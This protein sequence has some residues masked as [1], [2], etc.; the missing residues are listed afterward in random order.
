MPVI[1]SW[2]LRGLLEI[3]GSMVGRVLLSLS[4][5]YVEY[6]GV[7][8][9]IDA[10]K[11]SAVSAITSFGASGLA[12]WAGFFRIDVHISIIISAIGVKVALNG[13]GGNKVRKL[14]RK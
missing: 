10:T 3:A 2:L 12:A 14:V 6:S 8:A 4:L 11:T 7:S 9:L 1:I 13:L 5:G